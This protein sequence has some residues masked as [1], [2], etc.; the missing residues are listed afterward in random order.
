LGIITQTTKCIVK[1]E[2][3]K[4]YLLKDQNKRISGGKENGKY[5]NN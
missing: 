5:K 4:I 2:K 3:R 1:E